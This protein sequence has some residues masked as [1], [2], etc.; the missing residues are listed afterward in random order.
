MSY[1]QQYFIYCAFTAQF[2][3]MFYDPFRDQSIPSDLSRRLAES[4]SVFLD[5]YEVLF[6]E[7]SECTDEFISKNEVTYA[8]GTPLPYLESFHNWFQEIGKIS[9]DVTSLKGILLQFDP[10]FDH[11]REIA[12][13]YN[14]K[15]TRGYA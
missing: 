6:Q 1:Q 2:I 4:E 3:N 15:I 9:I 12:V 5:L 14:R 8:Q 13:K 11:Y 7:M 10:F